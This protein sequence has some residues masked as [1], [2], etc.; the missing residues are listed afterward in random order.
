MEP[1]FVLTRSGPIK[2][3]TFLPFSPSYV[4]S[5]S[6]TASCLL[7]FKAITVIRLNKYRNHQMP[8]QIER[9]PKDPWRNEPQ[10][11]TL[12]MQRRRARREQQKQEQASVTPTQPLVTRYYHQHDPPET[13]GPSTPSARPPS[14]LWEDPGF[15]P[16]A[17][18]QSTLL[19]GL[20]PTDV[21]GQYGQQTLHCGD[22]LPSPTANAPCRPPEQMLPVEY[23]PSFADGSALGPLEGVVPLIQIGRFRDGSTQPPAIPASYLQ[24]GAEP[25]GGP[26]TGWSNESFGASTWFP[27]DSYSPDHPPQSP[28]LQPVLPSSTGTESRQQMNGP[29]HAEESGRNRSIAPPAPL[30]GPSNGTAYIESLKH[31][32]R[33]GRS[34]Y[35]LDQS[36]FGYPIIVA[37]DQSVVTMQDGNLAIKFATRCLHPYRVD[38]WTWERFAQ[39]GKTGRDSQKQRDHCQRSEEGAESVLPSAVGMSGMW[40]KAWQYAIGQARVN[41][42]QP[43]ATKAKVD[44]LELATGAFESCLGFYLDPEIIG[45]KESAAVTIRRSK[46]GTFAS[47][48][49]PELLNT[50]QLL[51]PTSRITREQIK[52]LMTMPIDP[53]IP[54]PTVIFGSEQL[55]SCR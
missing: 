29:S 43:P 16:Q 34:S 19:F 18:S 1:S 23:C 8:K 38:A 22:W 48:Q 42:E 32:D 26:E 37:I 12:H 6:S 21:I 24:P 27:A 14:D 36:K 7:S 40:S 17:G 5:T 53:S 4:S 41:D 33:E 50:T 31:S 28:F 47:L 52:D 51:M 45:E 35:F 55:P 2:R 54:V 11:S 25:F 49:S 20:T 9:N 15:D 46:P 10:L 30:D 3:V 44:V 39:E 13:P